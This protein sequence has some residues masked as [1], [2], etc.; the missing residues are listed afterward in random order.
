VP[1][2]LQ[3]FSFFTFQQGTPASFAKDDLL[4]DVLA[5]VQISSC[6]ARP[7][8]RNNIK[9]ILNHITVDS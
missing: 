3:M 4:A 7:E 5:S 8:F 1:K 9:I 2:E 6:K